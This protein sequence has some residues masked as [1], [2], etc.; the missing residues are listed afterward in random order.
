MWKLYIYSIISILFLLFINNPVY[1]SDSDIVLKA[2]VVEINDPIV[3]DNLYIQT[4]K[5]QIINGKYKGNIKEIE[6]PLEEIYNRP[7]KIGDKIKVLLSIFNNEEYIQ[8]YDFTRSQNYLWLFILF[9]ISL[10]VFLGFRGLKTL[11]PSIIISIFILLGVIP[12]LMV[13]SNLLLSSLIVI[14]II[15]SITA[16]IRLKDKIL[17]CIVVLSVIFCLYVSFLVFSGFANISY[18]SPFLGSVTSTNEKLYTNI[19]DFVYLS[20]LFIPLGGVINGSIQVIKYLLEEFSDIR[21]RNISEMLKVGIRISQ[22]ISAGEL[23]N[24][25]IIIL[26]IGLAGILFIRKEYPLVNFWD[27]GWFALQVI[28]MISSGLAILIITPMSVIFLSLIMNLTKKYK[29]KIGGQKELDLDTKVE[30]HKF[31]Y[32]K[33]I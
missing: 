27:N 14:G 8:F 21:N 6:I 16:W 31:K 25:L 20:S 19:M 5:V 26:S 3:I 17:T 24:L 4:V 32:F 28:Y 11:I 7:L 2:N 9:I 12:D 1:G 15:T 10:V 23:N 30:A 33:K 22:K 13:K 18:I 29:N